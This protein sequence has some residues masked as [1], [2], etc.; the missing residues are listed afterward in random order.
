MQDVVPG[1]DEGAMS[2]AD[3]F[4]Q[5]A[6]EV[7]LIACNADT[8]EQ[9]QDLLNLA[10]TWTQAALLERASSGGHDRRLATD[11]SMKTHYVS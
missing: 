9:K 10:R 1:T 5:F 8:D 4:W 2:K 6:R 11:A 7:M 3:Q